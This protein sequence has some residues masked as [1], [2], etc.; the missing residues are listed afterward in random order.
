VRRR[1]K[2]FLDHGASGAALRVWAP[3]RVWLRDRERVATFVVLAFAFEGILLWRHALLERHARLAAMAW[4][5]APNGGL[6][7]KVDVRTAPVDEIALLPGVGPQRAR[8]LV[9][10]RLGGFRP[11][12]A[13]DLRAVHGFGPKTVERLRDHVDFDDID[14]DELI[15][16]KVDDKRLDA[17]N[18]VNA[19]DRAPP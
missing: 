10:A 11:E 13:D 6:A 4:E 2:I 17:G 8:D 3:F 12:S 19:A 9:K 1:G 16:N 14:V 5:Q 7:W 15:D 18:A